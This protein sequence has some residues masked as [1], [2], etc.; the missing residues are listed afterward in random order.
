MKFVI[1]DKINQMRVQD[2]MCSRT[3]I[4]GTREKTRLRTTLRDIMCNYG[5][6]MLGTIIKIINV[7]TE[8]TA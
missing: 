3:S 7:E 4:D 5:F 6:T 2:G 1:V 8:Q